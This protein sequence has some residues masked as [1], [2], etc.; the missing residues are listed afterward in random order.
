MVTLTDRAK[1]YMQSVSEGG[2]V[3]LG[4][5]T[6]GCSGMQ[7]VWGLS[8]ETTH[9]RIQWSKP[10]EDILLLDPM[11]EIYITGSEIDYVEELG[12][13]FLKIVNPAAKSHCGCG[14]SFG[15]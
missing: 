12:G 6:G 5:K 1:N 11:A 13:N 8:Q 14:E 7:Y 15:I 4:V 3:T 2:Y 9:E 10:V